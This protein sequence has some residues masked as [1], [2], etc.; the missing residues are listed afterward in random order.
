VGTGWAD[1]TPWEGGPVLPASLSI[2]ATLMAPAGIVLR[3]TGGTPTGT[4]YVVSA[5]DLSTSVSNWVAIATNQF[6]LAGNFDC[7]NP[8]SSF[9]LQRFYSIH[10]GGTNA[11]PPPPTNGPVIVNQPQRQSILAGPTAGISVVA[12]RR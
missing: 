11:V 9:E 4:Y 3:G 5:A 12:T 2:T 7:T 1:V 8:V 10:V 6:D